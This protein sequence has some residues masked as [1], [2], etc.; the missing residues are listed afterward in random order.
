MTDDERLLTTGQA[1]KLCSVTRDTVLKWIKRGNLFPARTAGGHY[2]I[3]FHDLEPFVPSAARARNRPARV[4]QGPAAGARLHC[5][6]YLSPGGTAKDECEKC[7]AFQAQ[8]VWCFRLRQ[9]SGLESTRFCCGP[10]R[11]EDCPYYRLTAGLPARVLVI[12]TDANPGAELAPDPNLEMIPAHSAYEAAQ[13]IL[14]RPPAIIV[15]DE[16]DRGLDADGLIGD[17]L[18]DRRAAGVRIVRAV[19]RRA[20]ARRR[21][22]AAAPGARIHVMKKPLDSAALL[23]V[24]PGFQCAVRTPVA[25]GAAGAGRRAMTHLANDSEKGEERRQ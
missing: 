18:R 22:L 7:L 4:A 2:R 15:V 21:K 9:A 16:D 23:A 3:A 11:C 1:A 12:A 24:L 10:E 25:Q 5:W 20:A 19:G 14:Q 6:E 17:L 13:V 8:A